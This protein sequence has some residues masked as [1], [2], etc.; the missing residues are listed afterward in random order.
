MPFREFKESD[1]LIF[2]DLLS[3]INLIALEMWNKYYPSSKIKKCLFYEA[4]TN[5]GQITAMEIDD[6]ITIYLSFAKLVEDDTT[7]GHIKHEVLSIISS[8]DLEKPIILSIWGGNKNCLS[9]FEDKHFEVIS[10]AILY[11]HNGQELPLYTDDKL[12]E[13]NLTVKSFSEDVFDKYISLLDD[14]FEELLLRNNRPLRPHSIHRKRILEGFKAAASFDNFYTFWKENELIGVYI[15]ERNYI[16]M[17]AVH[18]DFQKRSYGTI[19]LNHS[20]NLMI[21]ERN[22]KEVYLYVQKMNTEAQTFYRKRGFTEISEFID[23][24]YHEKVEEDEE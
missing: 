1:M 4:D 13:T 6:Q 15:L 19:M 3:N 8:L 10:S 16:D 2:Q 11:R 23:Y 14:A 12:S 21:N 20:L 24:L 5:A 17:L 22:E 7:L 18:P 9:L